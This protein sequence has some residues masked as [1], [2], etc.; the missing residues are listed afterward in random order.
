MQA[1][2]NR[3][4]SFGG[5]CFFKV[6]F[7][8]YHKSRLQPKSLSGS[9]RTFFFLQI[10]VTADKIEK[11]EK[12]VKVVSFRKPK[13][14]RKE[15]PQKLGLEKIL[16]PSPVQERTVVFCSGSGEITSFH[17]LQHITKYIYTP[18]E[19]LQISLISSRYCSH[20]SW[21]L[22]SN[23][24]WE[25]NHS[26]LRFLHFPLRASSWLWENSKQ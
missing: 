1:F 17:F 6:Y 25:T 5:G 18:F 26:C 4:W 24:A 3:D 14:E 21:K 10:R 20:S 13:C 7:L 16:Q 22:F 2:E 15:Q 8:I 9:G 11:D 19:I 12:N 23:S